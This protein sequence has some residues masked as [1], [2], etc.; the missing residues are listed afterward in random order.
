METKPLQE[1]TRGELDNLLATH[2][3][4]YVLISRYRRVGIGIIKRIER[5]EYIEDA[6]NSV[7]LNY[8]H[9][10]SNG[11]ILNGGWNLRIKEE[12]FDGY[13]SAYAINDPCDYPF[14]SMIINPTL[15]D[16]L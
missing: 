8:Y 13:E 6:C 15:Y 1:M 2:G 4:I 7:Y 10:F 16:L 14:L 11:G 9:V 5:H 12:S 3:R